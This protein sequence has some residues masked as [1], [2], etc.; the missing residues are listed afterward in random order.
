MAP[1]L[2]SEPPPVRLPVQVRASVRSKTWV[3]APEI[4][5]VPRA[6]VVPPLPIR[7]VPAF[8]WESPLKVW[9]PVR[10]NEPPVSLMMEDEPEITPEKSPSAMRREPDCMVPEPVRVTGWLAALTREPADRFPSRWKEM[11][12]VALKSVA[13]SAVSDAP[14]AM[15]TSLAVRGPLP[16]RVICPAAKLIRPGWRFDARVTV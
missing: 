2:T 1:F 13:A 14:V 5:A 16:V 3:P 12:A 10:I 7:R 4:V 15:L 8:S 6:P 9:F 11:G